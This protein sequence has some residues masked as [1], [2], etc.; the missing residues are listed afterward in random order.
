MTNYVE[1]NNGMMSF[2]V[3]ESFPK[4]TASE[5]FVLGWEMADS[6]MSMDFDGITEISK[7]INNVEVILPY[8]VP[9]DMMI[10]VEKI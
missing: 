10:L 2:Y 3:G 1:F 7:V 9:L 6:I 8:P 5:D 4:A